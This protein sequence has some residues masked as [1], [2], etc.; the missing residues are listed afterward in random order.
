MMIY[1]WEG[2]D[3]D[4][5]GEFFADDDESARKVALDLDAEFLYTETEDGSIRIVYNLAV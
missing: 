2:F 5:S 1:Y 3:F 4:A